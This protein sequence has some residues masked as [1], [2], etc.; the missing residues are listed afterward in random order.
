M[1]AWQNLVLP[2]GPSGGAEPHP[3]YGPRENAHEIWRISWFHSRGGAFDFFITTVRAA[4]PHQEK[5]SWPV[6]DMMLKNNRNAVHT[7]K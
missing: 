2:Q 5:L 1:L 6:K 4:A 7:K 3:Y